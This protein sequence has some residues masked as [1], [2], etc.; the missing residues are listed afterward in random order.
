MRILYLNYEWSPR[1]STGA[2]TH[3]RELSQELTALGHTV[4]VVDR[5]RI[6]EVQESDAADESQRARSHWKTQIRRY[7]H[8]GAALIRA[9]RGIATE[10]DLIRREHPDIV[11]T[12][13]SLHQF[14]SIVAGARCGV[15][16]VYEVNAPAAYEYRRYREHYFIAPRFAE[17]LETR[18]LARADGM[19]VVSEVLREH[20][21]DLGVKAERIRTIPNGADVSRFCPEA[22]DPA[23]RKL[24]GEKSII[25]G[26]VGSFAR[27]HGTEQLG[28]A[29]DFLLQ[30]KP[31]VRFLLVG[32]GEMSEDLRNHCRS[33]GL[34]GRVHFTGHVSPGEVP[35]LMASA[36][37]LLAPYAPQD[38]FYLSPI[39]IFEYMA[40]GRAVLAANVGQIG[41]VIQDGIN[42]LL[43]E[44]TNLESLQAGLLRLTEDHDLRRRLGEEARRTIERR[45]TWRANAEGVE[46][47]LQ[48]VVERRKAGGS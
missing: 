24:L 26:F 22:S 44:P 42:G 34:D 11:L 25:V 28:H 47:L 33:E 30:R 20:F 35:A 16:V 18:M 43:Y 32:S 36:D 39:K 40:V 1:Q 37:I 29:I 14:S 4:R 2:L 13:H 45:Y 15:P 41:E 23:M 21:L 5:H 12:R 17:W 8:E 19:F 7:L 27:F 48:E 3:I 6:V 10:T 31:E 46:A 9:L 38:F